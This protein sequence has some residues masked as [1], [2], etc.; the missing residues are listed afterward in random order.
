[1]MVART[2]GDLQCNTFQELLLKKVKEDRGFLS[3][4]FIS[5]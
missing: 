3:V 2:L 1:M 5:G 4:L